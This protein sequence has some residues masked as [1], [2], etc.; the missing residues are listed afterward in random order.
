MST[1]KAFRILII[2]DNPNIH[3][4]FIKILT[5]HQPDK[6]IESLESQ[7]FGNKNKE[8]KKSDENKESIQMPIFEIDTASQGEEG[9]EKVKTALSEG[10]PYAMAFVDIRMPPGWDGIETIKHIW[11][12]DKD[13]QIVICTAYSDYSWEE[14]VKELGIGDNLLYLKKPF[15]NTAVRQ[16]AATLTKKWL[17]LQEKRKYTTHLEETIQE[18]TY[19]LQ[20]SLSEIRATLDSS[21]DGIL[22][23]NNE[24]KII[25]YNKKFLSMWELV[26]S[27]LKNKHINDLLK[28]I[29]EPLGK[30]NKLF[31]DI[32]DLDNSSAKIRNEVIKLTGGQVFEYYTQ[33]HELKGKIIGRVWSFR[34]ITNRIYMEKKLEYQATHDNLTNLPNRSL[35]IDRVKHSIDESN[36]NKKPFALLFLDLDNFKRINDSM[37]HSAGD[38]LLK[39]IARRIKK[40]IRTSDTLAR[41]GGDEFVLIMPSLGSKEESK[42]ILYRLLQSISEPFKLFQYD[43]SIT[44]S[45]GICLYPQDAKTPDELLQN[46]DLAMYVAKREGRNKFHFYEESLNQE[47]T[48]TLE[49]EIEL[50]RALENNELTLYYQPQ[51]NTKNNKLVGVEALIRWNHPAQG[52]ISPIEFMHIAEESNLAVKIGDWVLEN[53]FKQAKQ[54]ADDGVPDMSVSI[55]IGDSQI[56]DQNF[57]KKLD[58]LLETSQVNPKNITLEISED[59]VISNKKIIG[60]IKEISSRGLQ[61]S[62]DDFGTGNSS[63]SYLRD[64]SINQ[65]KIDKS[66]VDNIHIKQSDE[67]IIK[68][69]LSMAANLNLEVIAEGVETP[70]QLKFLNKNLCNEIQGYYFSKPLTSEDAMEFFKKNQIDHQKKS[71]KK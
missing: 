37:S 20:K 71:A 65:L 68:A 46:A 15:D 47:A 26:D 59:I 36:R 7:I 13:I 40:E 28:L 12:I 45:I 55:N 23:V 22:V 17:L 27:E 4:D 56:N 66:F 9:L 52:L 33:P 60:I 64:A 2:D 49:K 69:I 57:I 53:A 3:A 48:K 34:D 54:W 42:E 35:L 39:E 8:N 5:L 38:E 11:R 25:D 51:I 67:I 32:N 29:N 63:L 1:D 61:V 41:L 16:L 44:A 50:R 24:G 62:F 14:T 6:S 58:V 70:E 19:L 31:T 43:I 21:N 18:R 10:Q 30:S